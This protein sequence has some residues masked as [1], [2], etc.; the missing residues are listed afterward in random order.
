L[1]L[2]QACSP[3]RMDHLYFFPLN[4][5][6]SPLNQ[7]FSFFSNSNFII[8]LQNGWPRLHIILSIVFYNRENPLSCPTFLL[9][10][11]VLLYIY[12]PILILHRHLIEIKYSPCYIIKMD[13]VEWFGEIND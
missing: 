10:F 6:I 2:L 11:L 9:T 3:T 13:I 5:D 1:E 8:F 12:L 7:L 4:F